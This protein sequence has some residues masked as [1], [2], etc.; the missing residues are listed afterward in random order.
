MNPSFLYEKTLLAVFF[1]VSSLLLCSNVHARLEVVDCDASAMED[2]NWVLDFSASHVNAILDLADFLPDKHK[3]NLREVLPKGK[4]KCTAKGLCKKQSSTLGYHHGYGPSIEFC[5]DN[6][7]QPSQGA[8]RCDL[9]RII[10]HE[11]AHAAGV[12]AE[13]KHN[14]SNRGMG[15]GYVKDIDMVYRFGYLAQQYCADL[16]SAG[17]PT[18]WSAGNSTV[19]SSN[20]GKL[21]IGD[22]CSRDTQCSS[23]KCEKGICTCKVDGDCTGSMH[24]V[25]RLGKNFCVPPAY[26]LSSYCKS[27]KD[28]AVGTCNNN[29]CV[30]DKDKECDGMADMGSKPRCAKPV[31]KKNFCQATG[32]V[33]G[34]YCHKDSDCASGKC[35][36]KI[37]S[38]S[39]DVCE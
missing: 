31:G 36:N 18:D 16:A 20:S 27:N 37:T 39:K 25:K 4:I 9:V 2:I 30:C 12:P 7:R 6:I 35:K 24:C 19:E 15:Y 28:C 26:Y 3:D 8:T 14:E 13:A 21:A 29:L 32:V 1:S 22:Y 11:K 17:D 34:N 33:A 38:N 10:F 23:N 5:W